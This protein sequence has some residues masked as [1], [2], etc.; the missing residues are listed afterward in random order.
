MP[1]ALPPA[2][3]FPDSLWP[4]LA[5]AKQQVGILEGIGRTLPNPAI[6]LRPLADRES[7][8]S[9]RLEGTYVTSK[10]LLLF[11]FDPPDAKSLSDPANDQREVFNYRKALDHGTNS[12]LPLSLRLLREL[13][14][15]LL[16]NVRGR[17][18]SPGEFRK[19]Q[20]AIGESERFIPA[21][22]ER[23]MDCLDLLERYFH[24]SS[25]YDPLVDCFLI[26]YQFE[27][28]HPFVDGNGRVGRLLLA[29]MLQ[30]RCDLSKP[31]LYM[32]EYFER[33]RDEYVR[34]LFD[35]STLADWEGWIEFCLR[36]TVEQAKDAIH[37]CERLRKVREG[38]LQK[39]QD[40][41]GS[42][43]LGGIVERMFNSPFV[44]VTDIQKQFGVTYP[45]AKAD[46]ERL[47]NARILAPVPF[48]RQKTFY[49]PEVFNIAYEST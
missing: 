38:L 37:R 17:D 40:V 5:E 46:V 22:P 24:T 29:I 2:W 39:L 21:P 4:L 19:V 32:S 11:E 14:Q 20:V 6:L 45:T 23:V 41:G 16:V 1:H 28:I 34:R 8:N 10:E 15:I 47:V 7:I 36:G 9:S 27:T 35:V 26:H 33:N 3:Q 49:A 43:R 42:V 18:R 31:W 48:A 12:T 13:H 30:Q 44:R 25:P